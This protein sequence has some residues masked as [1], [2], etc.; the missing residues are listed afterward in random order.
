MSLP[1]HSKTITS[2]QYGFFW[3]VSDFILVINSLI[4]GVCYVLVMQLSGWQVS[5][6]QQIP[7]FKMN[8]CLIKE[9]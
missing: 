5:G 3:G 6:E 8:T 9:M 7:S 2:H 4:K 1:C